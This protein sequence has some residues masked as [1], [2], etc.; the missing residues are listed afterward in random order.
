LV[1]NIGLI[2]FLFIIGLEVD[3]G[4][5]KRNGR[6]S[7]A[8]SLAGMVLPFGLGAAVAVPIY[9]KYI[10]NNPD[11]ERDV[12][13]GH[14]LLFIG[15]SMSITAFP[16]LCRILTATKLLDTEVGVVVLSAGVGNDVVGWVLLALTLALT[17]E[18]AK[19][20]SSVYILL[21]AVGWSI[22][23]L[24]PIRKAYVWIVRRSGS[25]E[26]GGPT[27]GVMIITLMIVFTS[28]FMTG[29]I[30][31][32][33]PAVIEANTDQTQVFTPSLVASSPV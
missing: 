31:K 6:K 32:L 28:A 22:F 17:S 8:I 19:G 5:I 23:V 30:G 15:V 26:G 24:W 3:I 21:A 13:F 25:L 27:P 12:S 11:L 4:V 16:V 14:F 7:A 29:I 9:N 10:H 33:L 2:I 1:A 20:E 18:G